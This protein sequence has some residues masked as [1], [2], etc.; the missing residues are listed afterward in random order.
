MSSR[1]VPPIAGAASLTRAE[2]VEACRV[3]LAEYSADARAFERVA[4]AI[5]ALAAVARAEQLTPEQ[6]LIEL[7]VV[8]GDAP[9]PHSI[10]TAAAAESLRARLVTVAI[11]AYFGESR[12]S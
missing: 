12:V 10:M 4:V 1:P 6:M 5:R 9:S 2:A 3:A 11:R 7:K 8:L